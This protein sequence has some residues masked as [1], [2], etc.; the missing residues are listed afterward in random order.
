MGWGGGGGEGGGVKGG[1][2]GGQAGGRGKQVGSD[3]AAD[4]ELL[5]MLMMSYSAWC[6]NTKAPAVCASMLLVM[7]VL[8]TVCAS[9]SWGSRQQRLGR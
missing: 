7:K 2:G 5:S 1:R 4:D 3:T 6:C 9:C 8:A